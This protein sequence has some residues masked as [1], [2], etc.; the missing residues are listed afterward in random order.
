MNGMTRDQAEKAMIL[1]REYAA[2]S[3]QESIYI[4]IEQAAK[5]GYAY[6]FVDTITAHKL[7]TFKVYDALIADLESKGYKIEHTEGSRSS[8]VS[9][10]IWWA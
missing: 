8:V 1:G 5:S 2:K 6:T 10:T 7:Q 9:F 4:E 3:L